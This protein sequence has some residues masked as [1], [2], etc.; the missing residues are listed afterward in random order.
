[1]KRGA[2]G[3]EHKSPQFYMEDTEITMTSDRRGS[4]PRDT[5]DTP[6]T[7]D[8]LQRDAYGGSF[9]ARRT[10]PADVP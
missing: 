3:S 5:G 8:L 10:V 7:S 9:E 2:H 4:V 6:A 1:M